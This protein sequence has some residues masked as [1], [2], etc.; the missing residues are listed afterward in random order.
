MIGGV[1]TAGDL[2]A[3]VGAAGALG[4]FGSPSVTNPYDQQASGEYQVAS[5]NAGD[6]S[7]TGTNAL[8]TY[9]SFAPEDQSLNQQY[10]QLMMGQPGTDTYSQQQLQRSNGDL[11]TN[12]GRALGNA[13]EGIGASGLSA[14]GGASS[15]LSGAIA[16][17][18][19]QEA[20][21]ESEAQ[22]NN[23]WNAIQQR[24]TNVGN[25]VNAANTFANQVY[26]QGTGALNAGG[27]LAN[28]TGNNYLNM[29]QQQIQDTANAQSGAAGGW[30]GLTTGAGKLLGIA[31]L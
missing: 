30:A 10:I 11:A 12:Y 29:G 25:A 23:A 8:N 2:L 26:G 7:T 5:N 21:A 4:L 6:L 31:G 27:E 18:N 20:G 13:E 17:S 22:N 28:E 1:N 24:Y 15:E 9:S 3:G 16:G 19:L 14:P